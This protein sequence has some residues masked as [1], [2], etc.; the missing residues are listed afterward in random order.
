M[1]ALNLDYERS[2][3]EFFEGTVGP[4]VQH[5]EASEVSRMK[6]R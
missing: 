5:G 4:D 6:V 2:R 1:A 3:P